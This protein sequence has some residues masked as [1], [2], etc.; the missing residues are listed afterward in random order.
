MISTAKA[1][2]VLVVYLSMAIITYP[3]TID[4]H[5][6]SV[7]M[8]PMTQKQRVFSFYAWPVALIA[9]HLEEC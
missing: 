3:L 7:C 1:I 5:N 9:V 8:A 6:S 2:I 4:R